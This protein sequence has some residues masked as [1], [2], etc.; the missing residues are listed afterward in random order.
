MSVS[1]SGGDIIESDRKER[2]SPLKSDVVMK[3]KSLYTNTTNAKI[4]QMYNR[5]LEI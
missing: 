1:S 2:E 5:N 4:L 3:A